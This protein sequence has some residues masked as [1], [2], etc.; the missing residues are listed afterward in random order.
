M[1]N[2]YTVRIQGKNSDIT[3]AED[4]SILDAALRANEWLPHSCTQGTCGTCKLKVRCGE[5]R[6]N[7]S[8][9]TP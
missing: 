4:Q 5:V 1:A 6:H 3:V 9:S 8:P 7:E 2:K